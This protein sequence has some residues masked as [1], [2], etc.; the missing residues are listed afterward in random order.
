MVSLTGYLLVG[1]ALVGH[2][3]F[4]RPGAAE[5]AGVL[6]GIELMFN[7]A[8]INFVSFN[9]YPAPWGTLGPGVCDFRDRFGRRR[10]GGGVGPGAWRFIETLKRCCLKI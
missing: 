9:R 6:I 5:Y 8:N 7:A 1:A 3:P 10:S 4:W 2:W